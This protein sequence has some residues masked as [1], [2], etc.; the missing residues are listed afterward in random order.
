[1]N[2]AF[3]TS[4]LL[5]TA[6]TAFIFVGTAA[7]SQGSAN[8]APSLD[9][10]TFV[11]SAGIYRTQKEA[12]AAA[13]ELRRF[14]DVNAQIISI[15]GMGEAFYRVQLPAKNLEDARE[16]QTRIDHAG[17]GYARIIYGTPEYPDVGAA[18]VTGTVEAFDGQTVRLKV[19]RMTNEVNGTYLRS[20]TFDMR[21]KG[22]PQIQAGQRIRMLVDSF[23]VY[24][25]EPD[26]D[27]RSVE[28]QP[29]SRTG[30]HSV[31]Q[32][33]A[34]SNAEPKPPTGLWPR[35]EP[36]SRQS[37]PAVSGQSSAS[38]SAR[39]VEQV[40]QCVKWGMEDQSYGY[41][42]GKG[43]VAVIKN[44]CSFRISIIG[45]VTAYSPGRR[46][47]SCSTPEPIVGFLTADTEARRF[48]QPGALN[49][50]QESRFVPIDGEPFGKGDQIN[51]GSFV[52][53]PSRHEGKEIEMTQIRRE[54]A[55]YT[56]ACTIKVPPPARK[57]CVTY[58]VVPQ[59][60]ECA[61][62]LWTNTCTQDLSAKV[63]RQGGSQ[64]DSKC[65]TL[66][67]SPGSQIWS[68]I[69]GACNSADTKFYV[70]E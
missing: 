58:K 23:K 30:K 64:G 48:Y 3:A 50:G 39:T 44:V 5:A 21:T 6:C 42:L 46:S 15:Q 68:S 24:A 63:C 25:L 70:E 22:A 56:G 9:G 38:L 40:P 59:T 1:M 51:D 28:A 13:R 67:F 31:P 60:P 62:T 11:A 69:G 45:C 37:S 34:A 35:K 52:V 29:D 32:I 17:Q 8:T 18:V 55:L 2:Y 57:S 19:E 33:A 14:G 65:Q 20:M 53:C 41:R 4:R 61:S 26:N 47:A 66:E 10:A 27:Q 43:R 54:N 49:P 36:G 16:Q 12:Q 7:N